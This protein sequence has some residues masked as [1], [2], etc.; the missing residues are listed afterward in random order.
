VCR[1]NEAL[2][3]EVESLLASD[4]R[5]KSFLES[6]PHLPDVEMTE[7]L[8]GR[9]I[10]AYQIENRIGAGGMGEVYEAR[11]TT[12]DRQVAIKVLLPGVAHDS[13]SLIRFRREAQLLAS[14]NHPH[15]AQIH[16]FEDAGDGWALVMELVSGPTLAER[17]VGRASWDSPAPTD[18]ANKQVPLPIAEALGIAAQI[19][20]ALEAAHE[21]GIIHRDLKPA[22]I[23][24][25]EDGTVKVLDFGLA[26][27]LDQRRTQ[28]AA[29]WD[30]SP[31]HADATRTGAVFGTP[32]YMSPEQAR[33]KTADRRAD[34]WAF[35]CILYEMLTGRRAFDGESSTDVLDAVNTTDPEWTR[36]PEKTPPAIRTLL[37]RCLEKNRARRLDSATAA[38]LEID[39]ALAA[40]AS[41][42]V[43]PERPPDLASVPQSSADGPRQHTPGTTL[44]SRVLALSGVALIVTLA[45]IAGFRFGRIQVPEDSGSW[46][47]FTQLTDAAGEETA[48]SLAPDGASFAYA[49]RHRGSWDIYV[50][51]VG[52]RTT[53]PVAASPER[54]ENWPVFSPDGQ[55]I[56]FSES[57]SDGGIF[58]VGAT[59][60][61]VTRLTDFGFNPTWS[62]RGDQIAFAAEQLGSPYARM[63]AVSALWVVS[64]RGGVPTKLYDGDA[65]QPSWSPSG[66]RVAFWQAVGGQ[67]DLA[68]ISVDGRVATVLLNDAPLDWSPTWSPDGR[69]VY[70]SSDRGG[71]MGIWRLAVNE[72]TGQSR[73]VP[74][75]IGGSADASLA[76]AS[77][78]RDGRSLLFRSEIFSV[79]P[80][81]VPF[82]PITERA[83]Q[84]RDIVRGSGFLSP[85]S[86]SPD[87]QWLAVGTAGAP[88]E[89]IILLRADG[90]ELRRLTDDAA[91]DRIPRFTPDGTSLT[92]YSNREGRYGAWSIATDGSG[93]TP[94]TTKSD[95]DVLYP[96]L[97]PAALML[98]A[99]T[100]RTRQAFL[101]RPPWPAM[102]SSSKWLSGLTLGRG[103]LL[104]T[105][106]SPDGR[107]L[108]GAIK[109]SSG[110]L[111]GLG[112]YQLATGVARAVSEDGGLP[113]ASWLP[114]SRRLM[115][116]TLQ[117]EL[118]VVDAMSGAR[119][120]VLRGL[121]P[122]DL[123]TGA[124]APDGRTFYYGGEHIESNIWRLQ[125]R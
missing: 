41:R 90:S 31:G 28:D 65:M 72:Q 34:L 44:R 18:G 58:V 105:L 63:L 1:G 111:V 38:R 56:A 80:V 16:G 61:S 101:L 106:W 35:G 122:S 78:S 100:H 79:I 17:I 95:D 8:E 85:T 19:A 46:S 55:R 83:G 104:P 47:A 76:L 87:G 74:E 96:V 5:A 120:V 92:F 26:T 81:A 11:D 3:Q 103:E 6:G 75:P 99:Q 4:E 50:Q 125:R 23:K 67:R 52:G 22:N 71:S 32:A 70:F 39:D 107:W 15:I 25:R 114:D 98:L 60:E 2:H 119:R 84:P 97:A 73:G 49:S 53:I 94:L 68:T 123:D 48:P 40:V 20:A 93:L 9:R 66:A 10:G 14:L 77:F 57:D 12:L 59:G 24:V 118:V 64:A 108:S 91:R 33:G 62:P 110:A 43:L 102:L 69:Y 112:V 36:L 27:A 29:I 109:T 37:R 116:V 7:S 124:V 45:S 42:V 89:D 115:Y 82:D 86:V 113:V 54:H 13:E 21:Q 121:A 51:R 88:Q 30:S 117:G